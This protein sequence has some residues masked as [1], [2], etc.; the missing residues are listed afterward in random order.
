MSDLVNDFGGKISGQLIKTTDWN[1]M[2]QRV[3]D[4]FGALATDLGTRIDTLEGRADD[5]DTRVNANEGRLDNAELTLDV[6]RDRLRRLDL[7]TNSTRFAIGQ[8]GT[9][10]A[11][12]T[13]LE[14][15]P[16]DLSTAATRP[17]VDFVTVWGT[18]KATPGFVTRG[19]A[20]DQTLSVQV[21]AE[22]V[23]QALIRANH[24]EAFAEEEE[25]EMQGFLSTRPVAGSDQTIADLVL[26][27]NTPRDGAMSLAYQAISSEYDRVA[28][29][30]PPVVQRY[31]DTYY[32]TQP[33]RAAGNYT[34]VFSQRWRDYRATVMAM[35]KPD[36][37]PTTADG[38]M[39]SASIQVTFRDWIAPWF[40]VDYLPGLSTLQLDY[41][42]RFRN[43]IGT[44]LGLSLNG[45]IGEVDEIIAGRGILGRQRDL[46]AVERAISGLSF[47]A[48][49]PPFMADLVQAVQFGSQVQHALFYSQ[50]VTPG[51]TGGALGFSA[52]AGS[53]G[54]AAAEAGR[55]K[56]ELSAEIDGKLAKAELTL[57]NE[58]TLSQVAFQEELLRDDGPI[59]SVQRDV[60]AFSGEVQGMQRLLNNKADVELISNIVGTLPG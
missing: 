35:V 10:T 21:N 33:S 56:G 13:S 25:L 44:D 31:V 19:G 59:L 22:G 41:A 18:L 2:L 54:Q 14:G 23:A 46:L 28:D 40:T 17:W 32:I 29:S 37:N 51:D 49:P 30:S 39:A 20:G 50:E 47:D 5:L 6:L 45:I 53:R 9:I 42:S 36:S 1:G 34:S 52:I 60:K 48:D 55:V 16:L 26:S 15:A 43:L 11:R 12:V 58:V 8:R 24:A 27:S 57:R 38:A 4:M 7:S 3:E